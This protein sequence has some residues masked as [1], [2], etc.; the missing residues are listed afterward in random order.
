MDLTGGGFVVP[1]GVVRV[2][3]RGGAVAPGVEAV[4]TLVF[5]F[6]LSSY[7]STSS[8]V[9]C[10]LIPAGSSETMTSAGVGE[11]AGITDAGVAVGTGA[12]K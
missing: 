8:G 6:S 5:V 4:T 3:T 7:G 12:I 1:A 10:S 9:V 2:V 11:L